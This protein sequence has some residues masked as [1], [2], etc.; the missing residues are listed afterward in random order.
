MMRTDKQ[1]V[2]QTNELA[3]QLY[4]LLGYHVR[5]GYRFDKAT[6]PHEVEAWRGACAAQ[7]LLTDTDPEDAL[8]NVED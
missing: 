8:A 3:R 6:H 2:E 1:V 7:R 5:Q 4:E